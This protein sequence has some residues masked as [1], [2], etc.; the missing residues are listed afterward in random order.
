MAISPHYENGT[1]DGMP[2]S[3]SERIPQKDKCQPRT[4]DSQDGCLARVYEEIAKRNYSLPRSDR[5]LSGEQGAN[6]R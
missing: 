6:W 1:S 5:G 3:Q 2:V 4:D